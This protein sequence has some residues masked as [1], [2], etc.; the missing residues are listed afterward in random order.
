ML[1]IINRIKRFFGSDRAS[2]FRAEK[3]ELSTAVDWLEYYTTQDELKTTSASELEFPLVSILVLTYNNLI[4][5]QTCLKS[6]YCNT[7]YPNFEII[8]VDN[9]SSDGTQEWLTQFADSHPNLK[10]VLSSV[11]LGFSGGNNLA[12]REAKGHYLVFL[13]NDTVVTKGWVERLLDRLI[14]DET[15]G[16]V[17]PVTN[18]TGN[19]AR[20]STNYHSPSE[21]E[22]F[23]ENLAH[24][25]RGRSFDIRMLAFYCVMAR[26]EE[27][28]EIGGLDERFLVGMF[29]DD[30]IAVRYQQAGKRVV[31]AD[32]VFIHHFQSISFGKLNDERYRK[33][34]EENRKKYED[35]WGR[36]WEPY[37]FRE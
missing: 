37:K 13:N 1:R 22:T 29:E 34:F 21:M 19:E 35:K 30:D 31:C 11:N 5:T 24:Q 9:A 33:I 16:L 12:A 28:L 8:V 32:D 14:Y 17:G 3:H 6:I 23:A 4:Y 2:S 18:S 20:I 26:K 27:Y 10:L 7:T 25:M 15:I 36:A